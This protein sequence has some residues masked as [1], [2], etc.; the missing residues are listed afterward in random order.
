[1][2]PMK[3]TMRGINSYRTEQ[4]ID[5]EQLTSSGLFGIFGPWLFM[6][7]SPV[8]PKILSI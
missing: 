2:K 5:F 6:Q 4:T 3:L 8:P 1:M 7:S